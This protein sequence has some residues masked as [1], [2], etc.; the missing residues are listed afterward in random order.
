[1]MKRLVLVSL[2]L[3]PFAITAE[4]Q[5]DVSVESLPPVVVETVPKAGDTDVDPSIGEVR[6]TYRVVRKQ[7]GPERVGQ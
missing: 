1:M 6:V 5:D 4:A 2:L 7:R 3:L